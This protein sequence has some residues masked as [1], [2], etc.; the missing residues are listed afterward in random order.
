MRRL[1]RVL[2]SAG[3][4]PWFILLTPALALVPSAFLDQGPDQSARFTLFPF[5]LTVLDPFLR[6][7]SMHSI[8]GAS[9]VTVGAIAI[10]V[11]VASVISSWRFWGRRPLTALIL[12]PVVVPP[13]FVAFGLREHFGPD[14]LAR[15][16]VG[17]PLDWICWVWAELTLGVPLVALATSAA[18]GRV[19]P[20]W[21]HSARL[22]GAGPLRI[23]RQLIWPV[24]RPHA[25][26]GGAVVFTLTIAEPGAPLML[27]L[28]RTLGY[29]LVETATSLDAMP[30]A[31]ALG[32]EA[33][34]LAWFGRTLLSR[35]AGHPVALE[36]GPRINRLR[37]AGPGRSML[38]A[39]LLGGMI[40]LAWLPVGALVR[41]AFSASALGTSHSGQPGFSLREFWNRVMAP[42]SRALIANSILLAFSVVLVNL[43]SARSLSVWAGRRRSVARLATWTEV[44]PPLAI[45]VGALSLTWLLKVAAAWFASTGRA[46]GVTES[47]WRWL[48][49]AQNPGPLLLLALGAAS[50]A[51]FL[52]VWQQSVRRSRS[53]LR[54]AAVLLGASAA[55]ARRAGSTGWFGTPPG[56]AILSFALAM[57]NLAPVLVLAPTPEWRTLGPGLLMLAD[58]PGDART[59]AA[60]LATC[61]IGL[62][63]IALAVASRVRPLT[64]GVWFRGRP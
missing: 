20:A 22:A 63:L 14:G 25:L 36:P 48:D 53:R 41:E 24:L 28:R 59:T 40:L 39:S 47:L 8:A 1:R 2:R 5:A 21:I 60:S 32:I 55:Q 37:T 50:Q 57:S 38:F 12:A 26:K 15:T 30:R 13:F 4:I 52:N 29:Q 33:L 56:V 62:N 43:A 27:G 10:G 42:E 23:W 3:L 31:A 51:P 58:G 7:A 64:L 35:W 9:V 49:P 44:F 17:I 34:A 6:I 18:L 45:G 19:E 11:T 54:D 46:T 16:V 61:A